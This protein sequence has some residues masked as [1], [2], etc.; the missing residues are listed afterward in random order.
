MQEEATWSQPF[1]SL[2]RALSAARE[3]STTVQIGLSVS[4][5]LGTDERREEVDN[6]SGGHHNSD[7]GHRRGLLRFLRRR[8]R[9]RSKR[10]GRRA[11]A[12]TSPA[13]KRPRSSI[14]PYD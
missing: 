4:E 12:Q 10:P 7:V 11:R 9:T 5:P 2:A 1:G 14:S 3:V 6:D 8:R 13:A